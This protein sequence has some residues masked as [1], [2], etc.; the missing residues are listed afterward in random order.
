MSFHERAFDTPVLRLDEVDS[1]NAEGLRRAAAGERGPLWITADRQTAGRGRSGRN[2]TQAPGN[3]A[4]SFV[5]SPQCELGAL[6]QLSLLAGVAVFDAI[7]KACG[8]TLAG[9]RLKW[10]NDILLGR[11]KTG[12]ILV[13]TSSWRGTTVAVIGIGVNV[14]SAPAIADRTVG[15]LSERQAHA[16]A[17]ALLAALDETLLAWL[18]T[19]DQARNFD[20]LR[21]AWLG[22][23]GAIGEPITVNL[24]A[25]RID[26][27]FHGID[28]GG[29]LL[30]R[31][32]D[33]M[34]RRL[35]YGDVTLADAAGRSCERTTDD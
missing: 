19:W 35:T 4:A 28:A 22:R 12:G 26:G 30:L 18:A 24:G 25:T 8:A 33:G 17:P 31:D 13:E 23:A 20:A 10:P 1:T 9:L 27:H 34:V 6:H 2:W 15:A 11:A 14:A 29:A 16:S 32:A 7:G 5:F 21:T 3:L